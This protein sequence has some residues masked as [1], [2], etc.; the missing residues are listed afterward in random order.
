MGSF[1]G[2]LIDCLANRS[3]TNK[4][5]MG[6]SYCDSCKR[7]I[8]WYDLFPVISYLIL[9]GRCRFCHKKLAK[10][11]LLIE[12][13]T[14]VMIGLLFFLQMPDWWNSY[15]FP[16]SFF[17]ILDVLFNAFLISVFII[18][19]ITDLKTGLIPDRITYPS[20]AAIFIYLLLTTGA[21]IYL[22]YS[23]LQVSLLGKYLLPPYGDFFLRH[24]LILA[25]PFTSGLIGTAILFIF[26]YSLIYFTKGKGMGGGDLKLGII[27]GLGLGW[28][29]AALSI[30]IAFLTGSLVG[31]ILILTRKKSFGQTIPFGPFLSL[32][33]I[34]AILWGEKIISYY[35]SLGR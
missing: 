11:Y 18:V 3:V 9:K 20:A 35:L 16:Q 33:S 15:I 21:K 29:K 17:Q 10:E 1:L 19:L 4:S 34:I 32:G 12:I 14:S 31:S 22:Y 28:E 5:F 7:I 2:S 30:F 27:I 25:Q 13:F 6:R 24:S 8:K 23:S 26:F